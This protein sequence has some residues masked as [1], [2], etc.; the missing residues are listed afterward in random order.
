MAT[1]NENNKSGFD[2]PAYGTLH[3]RGTKI[4]KNKDGTITLVSPTE[5][6]ETKKK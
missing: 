2:A 5:K 4:K 6:K 3:P 1:K